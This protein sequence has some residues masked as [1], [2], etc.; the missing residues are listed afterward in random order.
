MYELV[1]HLENVTFFG[2]RMKKQNREPN[3][4]TLL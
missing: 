2:D 3:P 1:D 4:V